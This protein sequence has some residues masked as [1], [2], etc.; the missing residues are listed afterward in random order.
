MH[1]GAHARD[2]EVSL[3]VLLRIPAERA[4]AIARLDA[5][6]LQRCGKLLRAIGNLCERRAPRG[7]ALPR[8]D[9][10]LGVDLAAV[11][12]D[13]PDRQGELL[14]RALHRALQALVP[15]IL[16]RGA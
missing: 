6:T 14:H 1:D 9:L 10:A 2:R 12:E 13:H 16:A 3:E 8:H 7:L 11:A 15:L 5:Q 4:D